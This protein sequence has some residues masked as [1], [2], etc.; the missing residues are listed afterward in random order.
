[1]ATFQKSI[2]YIPKSTETQ[3]GW[4]FLFSGENIDKIGVIYYTYRCNL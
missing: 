3:S 4:G 1:M 2:L